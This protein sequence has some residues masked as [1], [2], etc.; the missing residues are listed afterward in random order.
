MRNLNF[1]EKKKLNL[2]PYIVGGVFFLS[3]LLMGVFFFITNK[4][5]KNT[6]EENQA[7]LSDNAASVVLSRQIRQLDQL[8]TET[9]TVQETLKAGRYPMNEIITDVVTV[10]PNE[11]ERISSFNLSSPEQISIVLE[12]TESTMAEN[13]V[14]ALFEKDYITDVQ[15]LQATNTTI[16]DTQLRFELIINIDAN[17]IVKEET[18]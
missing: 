9:D 8:A 10:I 3:L 14:R 4:H 12:N 18:E 5:Y 2:L 1:F 17:R 6:I 13:I 15:F 11:E 16:E 7:W